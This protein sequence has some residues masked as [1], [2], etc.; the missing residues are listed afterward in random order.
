MGGDGWWGLSRYD[1]TSDGFTHY[2]HDPANPDSLSG[3]RIACI[4]E[5]ASGALWVST[6]GSGL[7]VLDRTNDASGGIGTMRQ[8]PPA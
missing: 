3:D 7:S 6:F 5:D 8:S 4:F 2:R 1:A